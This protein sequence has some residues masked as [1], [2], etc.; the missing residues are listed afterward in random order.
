MHIDGKYSIQQLS[1]LS[2]T[3]HENEILSQYEPHEPTHPTP[4]E[5]A[6]EMSSSGAGMSTRSNGTFSLCSL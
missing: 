1:N 3:S 6:L 4:F 5:P 2:K